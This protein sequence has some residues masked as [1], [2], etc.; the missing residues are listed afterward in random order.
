MQEMMKGMP[1]AEMDKSQ[2]VQCAENQTGEKLALDNLAAAPTLTPLTFS[3]VIPVLAP[4]VPSVQA[5]FWPDVPLES[6]ADPPYLQT[7]RLRI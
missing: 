2:P 1:C 4:A 3:F 7:R 6:G 5:S